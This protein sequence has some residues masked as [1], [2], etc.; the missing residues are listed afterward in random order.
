MWVLISLK[1]PNMDTSNAKTTN[2]GKCTYL[3][4]QLICENNS[5]DRSSKFI[6]HTRYVSVKWNLVEEEGCDRCSL[7]ELKGVEL[8]AC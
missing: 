1:T 4:I 3:Y 6:T 2:I 7:L 8:E 5:N